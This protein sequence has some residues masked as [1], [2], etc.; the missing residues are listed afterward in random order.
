MLSLPV[1]YDTVSIFPRPFP[2][3]LVLI[4]AHTSSL[5]PSRRPLPAPAVVGARAS[6]LSP[7]S[8]A[9]VTPL[10][11]ALACGRFGG[12]EHRPGEMPTSRRRAPPRGSPL[13]RTHRRYTHAHDPG[14]PIFCGRPR[15]D[16]AYPL[17]LG[18]PWTRE[19]SSRRS[20]PR[21]RVYAAVRSEIY[22]SAEP[23]SFKSP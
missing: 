8:R 9:H 19:P 2:F 1:L 20:S 6:P 17:G 12:R 7:L 3:L 23:F 15:L 11:K 5:E 21:L 16:G 10:R 18:P 13:R 4:V 22:G 14:H